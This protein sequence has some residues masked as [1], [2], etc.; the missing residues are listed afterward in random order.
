M[1]AESFAYRDRAFRLKW[2]LLLVS[3]YYAFF[4]PIHLIMCGVP[5]SHVNGILALTFINVFFLY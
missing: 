3:L 2:M 1:K 5:M 4:L